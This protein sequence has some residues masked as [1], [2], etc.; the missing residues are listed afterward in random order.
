MTACGSDISLWKSRTSSGS[1]NRRF[2]HAFLR[3]PDF[4]KTSGIIWD[5]G[6]DRW[7]PFSCTHLNLQIDLWE[8]STGDPLD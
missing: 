5:G 7:D 1:P 6:Y 4:F 3:I 2:V 8:G